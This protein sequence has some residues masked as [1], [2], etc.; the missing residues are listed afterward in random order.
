MQAP[1]F[2]YTW[3][4]AMKLY[5]RTVSTLSSNKWNLKTSI[6]W[7]FDMLWRIWWH[8]TAEW[9]GI[10]VVKM[11]KITSEHWCRRDNSMNAC[12]YVNFN[13]IDSMIY[14]RTSNFYFDLSDQ[15]RSASIFSAH[16]CTALQFNT[17]WPYYDD[18]DASMMQA[19]IRLNCRRPYWWYLAGLN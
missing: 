9:C 14:L 19:G 5:T 2:C 15:I 4:D 17:Q 11:Y 16:C 6:W 3:T 18:D 8:V 1:V 10:K 12:C 13:K 7:T